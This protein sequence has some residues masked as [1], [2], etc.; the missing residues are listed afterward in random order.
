MLKKHIAD[1]RA[2]S[3]LEFSLPLGV[4]VKKTLLSSG[5]VVKAV[6]MFCHR[7]GNSVAAIFIAPNAYMAERLEDYARITFL[8]V[9]ALNIP[10]W[11][12]EAEEEILMN[13]DLAGQALVLT[14]WPTPE[15]AS[16]VPFIETN[17][18]FQPLIETH[19]E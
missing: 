5:E 6:I 7:C 14:V 19:C 11:I 15:L 2:V 9:N 4:I 10:A 12:V 8:K 3:N 13:G 18:M 16:L 17:P 1:E